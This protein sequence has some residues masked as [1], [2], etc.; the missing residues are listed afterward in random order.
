MDNFKQ[1]DMN[2]NQL[3]ILIIA[4]YAM[5]NNIIAHKNLVLLD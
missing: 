5:T 1:I 3:H 2:E 4:V